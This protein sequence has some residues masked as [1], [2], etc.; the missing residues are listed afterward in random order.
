MKK[1]LSIL[2]I[3][4]ISIMTINVHAEGAAWPKEVN[5]EDFSFTI[6]G[7]ELDLY[8]IYR[9]TELNGGG[10][11][12][13]AE[14]LEEESLINYATYVQKSAV[15]LPVTEYE[16]NPTVTTGKIDD[17]DVLFVKLNLNLTKEKIEA[18]FHD[19][20]ADV[21]SDK[22]YI[23]E[24]VMNYKINGYPD[25]YKKI[26]ENDALRGILQYQ[27]DLTDELTSS[28]DPT[29]DENYFVMDRIFVTGENGE[30]EI[31]Y[32]DNLKEEDV[33]LREGYLTFYE[34]ENAEKF[35][36]PQYVVMFHNFSNI[37][38]L[39]GGN[40]DIPE[41]TIDDIPDN[42][43]TDIQDEIVKIPDTAKN[44]PY[45]LYILGIGIFLAGAVIIAKVLRQPK[46]GV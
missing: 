31:S 23:I 28:V 39:L 44:V 7:I 15:N 21:G 6:N 17:L 30:P 35:S 24:I 43:I 20:I 42:P 36:T 46:K 26:Y 40:N 41:P 12:Q 29:L 45:L 38:I 9:G 22:F 8:E 27:Y 13:N 16:M 3:I 1:I 37:D 10:T 2:L 5:H 4:V 33:N 11:S 19:D 32:T 14:E 18:L 34:D 25:K